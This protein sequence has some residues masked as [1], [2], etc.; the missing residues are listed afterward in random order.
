M[1]IKRYRAD[2]NNTIVN[3]Y[4][5][6]LT[7]RATGSNMGLADVLEVYS[8]YAR[9]TT[10]SQELSRALLKFPITDINS[11]RNSGRI[12]ASGSIS[13]Y[14]RVFNAQHAQATPRNS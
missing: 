9:A 14:L 1:G 7:T 5:S 4:K 11:D 6:D 3:S 12:P 13:F 10:S 2:L 8:I